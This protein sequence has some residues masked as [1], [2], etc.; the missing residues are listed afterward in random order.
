V[1]EEKLILNEG[2]CFGEWGMVY[3][4]DRVSSA[5]CLENCHLFMLDFNSFDF[6]FSKC[7]T[8][9]EI[10][11]K[12]LLK[13]VIPFFTTIKK[14][15]FDS[16]YKSFIAKFISFGEYVYTEGSPAESIFVIYQGL[17]SQISNSL[18]GL[19]GNTRLVYLDSG[20]VV[21]LEALDY[22]PWKK[23]N[24]LNAKHDVPLYTSSI[25]CE[26]ENV[27]TIEIKM[28]Y[29]TEE[30]KL[31]CNSLKFLKEQKEILR[32]DL[33]RDKIKAQ[34]NCKII[35]REQQILDLA[36]SKPPVEEEICESTEKM[37]EMPRINDKE[38]TNFN[39]KVH[40]KPDNFFLSYNIENNI[41]SHEKKSN[42]NNINNLDNLKSLDS[43][44]KISHSFQSKL[45]KS[46]L[47][48]LK[49]DS[50]KKYSLSPRSYYYNNNSVNN[51]NTLNKENVY[52]ETSFSDRLNTNESLAAKN[53]PRN[54]KGVLGN[55]KFIDFTERPSTAVQTKRDDSI[56]LYKSLSTERKKKEINC[57]DIS[58]TLGCK[59]QIHEVQTKTTETKVYLPKSIISNIN[60]W[61][62]ALQGKNFNTGSLNIPLVRSTLSIKKNNRK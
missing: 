19:R 8:K 42:L 33:I 47:K 38:Q 4:K 57:E 60:Y 26:E 13:K 46:K 53:I 40:K 39:F 43:D 25:K 22:N 12:T 55:L 29:F 44:S 50:S 23:V 5:Y 62:Y 51:L 11:R 10:D 59:S 61:S 30:R 1:E 32:A 58:Q 34:N 28:S 27:I 18:Q 21:G 16:L 45:F 52:N 24:F 48:S 14:S 36:I 49:N 7:M 54:Y 20:T 17:C 37:I 6:C 9:A 2:Q 35:Y 41:V 56:R 15:R 3:K 31:F